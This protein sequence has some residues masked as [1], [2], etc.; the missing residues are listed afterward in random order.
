VAAALGACLVLG[1]A[2]FIVLANLHGGDK[3]RSV[4]ADPSP[5]CAAPT[6]DQGASPSCNG[7]VAPT[8]ASGSPAPTTTA[9]PSATPTSSHAVT[10]SQCPVAGKNV[11]GAADPW[12][13]CWPGPGNTGVPAG[14]TLHSCPTAI[15]AAGTFDSCRFDGDLTV[16]APGVVITRS[17]ITGQVVTQDG[18]PANGLTIRD[19]TIACACPSTDTQTSTGVQQD[20]YTLIRVDLSVPGHGIA[21][22]NNVTVR[23]TWFHNIGNNTPSHKDGIFVGNG[24]NAVIDHNWVT[25]NDTQGCTSAIGLLMDFGPVS[26]YTITHNHLDG[27]GA[28]CFYGGGPSQKAYV[29]DHITFTDNVFGRTD[30]PKCGFYGPVA[31]WDVNGVGQVWARNTWP[32]GTP[33]PPSMG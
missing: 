23:D 17:R 24:A 13:G 26:H 28:F 5:Q 33:V 31:Y 11:A 14:L 9:K 21:I 25:C 4:A 1:A 3:Q 6:G 29:S 19:S 20:G 7:I 22:A 16:T 8:G 27:V 12:G 10:P 15:R 30:E 32:D 18:M 2:A